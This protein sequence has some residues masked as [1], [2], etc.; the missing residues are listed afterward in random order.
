MRISSA[1]AVIVIIA[2]LADVVH[3]FSTGPAL[4]S[5]Q[6]SRSPLRRAVSAQPLRASKVVR[7]PMMV[8]SAEKV[9]A[10]NPFRP[11]ARPVEIPSSLPE[12][13][14][15]IVPDDGM[16]VKDR[17][18]KYVSDGELE[19]SD[20][21]ILLSWMVNYREAIDNAQNDYSKQ[22]PVE[23][24]FAVLA[25]LVRKE[26]KRPHYF[27][28]DDPTGVYWEPANKHHADTR[29]FDYQKFGIEVT[30]PLID[31]AKSEVRGGE[32]IQ[33]IKEQLAAGENVV[34][35]SNHQSESDTHCI[36][37]LLN[38]QLNSE[39]GKLA[40]N[41]VFI[42]GERV[43]RDAIVVPFS[44][45]CNLLTVYSKKHID[46]EPDLKAA[47]MSHN[48]RTMKQ[49]G[50]LFYKG[51]TCM[52]FAPS[53]GR[54]R[55]NSES[56]KVELSPF[57][58]NA[59]EMIRQVADKAGALKKTHFYAMALA[60]H[61]IFPPPASVGGA[62]GEER[63]VNYVPLKLAVSEE[64]KVEDPEETP[65]M[66]PK[67]VRN[68]VKLARKQRAEMVFERMKQDYLSIGGLDQ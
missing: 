42:A 60:T 39:F 14:A 49:L 62:F 30:R 31:W 32:N 22:F 9:D 35:C 19:K 23:D 45:G 26:R 18:A 47:K 53:G 63:V 25:E 67:D 3:G 54:D 43:L 64:I 41:V 52:W 16:T 46:S 7:R 34:F 20:G 58:A 8:A 59:I 24:Y 15:W 1:A 11:A 37:T 28:K 44:R 6:G 65:G 10:A 5:L 48:Q 40:T 2:V 33:K 4:F 56:G 13:Y 57:D 61:N 29:F 21:F 51:G 50:G 17:I 36:F 68:A 66:D 55:R 38:D 27:S 12:D